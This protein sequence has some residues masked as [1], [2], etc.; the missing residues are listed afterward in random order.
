LIVRSL[1]PRAGTRPRTT[2]TNPHSQ[3]TQNPDRDL[4]ARLAARL[5]S[6]PG[7]EER[8][9]LVSVPGARALWLRFDAGEGNPD[10]FMVGREFAH[11]HPLP[12]GSLHA[13][14]PAA[15][16]RQAVEAGW[17]EPH[18]LAGALGRDGLV[19]LYAPRT[20]EELETVVALVS[21]AYR[22]ASGSA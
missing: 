4:H 1:P 22:F 2:P 18:P 10:A 6:F 14:L 12:D 17:A 21:E 9:S 20:E 7:V 19:M 16:A 5:F 8:P 13:A 15:L 3:L 11:L